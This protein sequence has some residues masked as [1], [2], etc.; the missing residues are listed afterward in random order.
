MRA[1]HRE[2]GERA[3]SKGDARR[4]NARLIQGLRGA[5]LLQDWSS[6]VEERPLSLV[7]RGI[8]RSNMTNTRASVTRKRHWLSPIALGLL[9]ACGAGGG[10]P[11]GGGSG[12]GDPGN[13]GGP[14]G[15][16]AEGNPLAI[17]L[18]FSVQ[19]GSSTD[20]TET[21]RASVPFPKGG[22][23]S[24]AN[25]IVSGHQT[26]WQSM[27]FWS[28]G[29]LKMAQA[30][31]TDTLAAGETKQYSVARDETAMSGPFTRNEWVNQAGAG[32]QLGA[33]V[34]DTFS[35]DYRSV[36]TG[37]GEIVQETPLLQ[38]QRWRTYH[39][40]LS[41]PGIGRDYLSSTFYVTEFRDMPFAIVDWVLGNDYLGT[42]NVPPGN[43]DPNLEPLGAVD[44]KRA[45]FLCKGMS[46]AQPYLPGKNAIGGETSHADGFTAFQ[47]MQD[48]FIGDAQ[49]RR[50]RFLL[51]FEPA[52]ADPLAIARWRET[53]D[54]MLD[55]PL[56]PLASHQT[57]QDTKAAGLLGGPIA[58]PAD[59]NVRADGD[60][61]SWNDGSHFGTWAS[62]GEI[63]NTHTTGTPRNHPLS[64]EL[65]HA[66]QGQHHRL[67]QRLE[68]M[69]WMQAARPYHLWSLTVGAEQR[70][71]LWGG[72]PHYVSHESLGRDSL[73]SPDPYAAYRGN[74]VGQPKAHGWYGYD[75]EHF[76][77]DLLFD[78][79]CISGDAWAKEELR[80]IGESLKATMRLR[81]YATANVQAVRAEGWC[82][83]AFAQVYQATQDV[84]IKEYAMRRV[85]EVVEVGRNTAH[86]SKAMKFQNNYPSTTFPL[87][88]EFFMP[89]QHGA[90]L[91]GFLGAYKSF[92]EPLLLTIAEDAIP[93]LD[94]SWVTNWN[95]PTLGFVA[96]GLRYYVPV[97]YNGTS[98]P[99]NYWD[100]T[101]GIG[102][103]FGSSALG[104]VHTFLIGGVFHLAE[105]T[106]DPAIRASAET[107]GNHLF[108]TLTE[109]G[110]WNKWEYCVPKA[111]AEP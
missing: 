13:G 52:G 50:Y 111:Y 46:G 25:L 34:R 95:D 71:L 12:G 97:D 64:P 33:E 61:S 105:L 90:M 107:Y 48:T 40:A 80:Q 62:H 49:T 74:S 4:Q 17:A 68:Q 9:A 101:P 67:L 63:K 58:G 19:N 65:A 106:D 7:N 92:N 86:A 39:T 73:S 109:N 59:A 6:L 94:Y 42:D 29:T 41:A 43:T 81:D 3:V 11:A 28:D 79:W 100:N 45:R 37:A 78:Y 85:N 36:V 98:I 96:N 27:Q 51:R 35:V 70:L 99:A 26:S 76:S 89:W 56:F 88:H 10:A 18:G 110:R 108:G 82:M 75:H 23:A 32:L 5:A 22:Y 24:T 44:V 30:Q 60:F 21:I 54:A 91:Y 77:A 15:P 31:F 53:A 57:W 84:A 87:N 2:P 8:H 93:M 66:I 72:L 1:T 14:G 83:Q 69:A 38:T 102:V 55:R 20:R 103:R 47:V 104:G 16:G